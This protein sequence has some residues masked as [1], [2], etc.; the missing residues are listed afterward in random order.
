VAK[1]L[2]SCLEL[3]NASVVPSLSAGPDPKQ[4]YAGI[5]AN[6]VIQHDPDAGKVIQNLSGWLAPGGRLAI[7][8]SNGGSGDD[9]YSVN[10]MANT[11]VWQEPQI[12]VQQRVTPQ[13][14]HAA[15]K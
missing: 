4:R 8:T 5:L 11:A 15:S 2:M 1:R 7:T 13:E 10:W 9:S 6:H 12:F 3:D 14:W